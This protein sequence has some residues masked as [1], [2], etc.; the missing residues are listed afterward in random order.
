MLGRTDSRRRAAAP[1]DRLRDRRAALVARLAY[2]QVGQRDRLA[3]EAFAADDDA[4]SDDA[5]PPR[6]HLRPERG[7]RPRHD[8]R[9]RA[10]RRDAVGAHAAAPPARSPRSSSRI[11]G[12]SGDD[13]DRADRPRDAPTKKYV[14]LAHGLDTHDRRPDPGGDRGQGRSRRVALEPEPVRV[15]PQEGGGPEHDARGASSSASSTATASAST[16]SSSTT[17]TQLAGRP[18]DRPGPARRRR[19]R[20]IPDTAVVED[21]GTPGE[22]IRLTIDAGLQLALEQEILAAWAADK[23]PESVSARRH[24]PVHRRDP[25]RGDL[26]VVRRQRLRSDRGRATPTGSSTRSS[27]PSTSRARSSRC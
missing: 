16:A 5:Q 26:P 27:A 13:A 9:A 8:D 18:E 24:G 19:P 1:A 4:S 22:D 3:G 21:P 6:R 7:R 11:L 17:R 20:S 12:L 15:Y 10:P 25:R 2:W 23:A 14:V